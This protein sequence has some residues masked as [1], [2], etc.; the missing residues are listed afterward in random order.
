MAK[1]WI[2][3]PAGMSVDNPDARGASRGSPEVPAEYGA[4]AMPGPRVVRGAHSL[5]RGAVSI[6]CVVALAAEPHRL[7]SQPRYRPALISAHFTANLPPGWTAPTKPAP[8]NE[9]RRSSG[10]WAERSNPVRKTDRR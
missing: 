8:P 5:H 3:S 4:I 1:R 6:L 7:L 2:V 9:I 10:A